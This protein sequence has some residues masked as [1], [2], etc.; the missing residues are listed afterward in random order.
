MCFQTA[1]IPDPS[2]AESRTLRAQLAGAPAVYQANETYSPL[3]TQLGLKNLSSFLNG[4]GQTPGFLEMYGNLLPRITGMN[5]DN[6]MTFAPKMRAAEDAANPMA[7]SL[8]TNIASTANKE[9]GYGTNLTPEQKVQLDQSVRGGQAARGLGNGPADVFD[10][11]MAETG[12]GQQLLDQRLNRAGAA[13]GDLESF[14]G[15]PV[16]S[17]MG[18]GQTPGGVIG[19]AGGSVAPSM[20]SEFNPGANDSSLINAGMQSNLM[21]AQDQNAYAL[22]GANLISSY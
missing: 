10:E 15:N 21:K 14:Y 22:S 5:L 8:L 12:F 19:M 17:L 16:T 13:A 4:D 1:G 20:L 2:R 18:L 9:L 11:S 6:A 3:Y 7:S